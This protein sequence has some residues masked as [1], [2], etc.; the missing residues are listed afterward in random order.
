VSGIAGLHADRVRIAF[1]RPFAT[2]SGMWLEREAWLLLLTGADG[3]TGVGEAVLEPADGETAE[4]VLR[5]LI[6]EAVDGARAGR[7]PTAAELEGHGAPGRALRAALDTAWLDLTGEP[8]AVLGPGGAGVGVNAT[9]PALGPAASAEAARQAVEAG[10][11]TLK[12]KGGAERETE[13][14][15][16]RVRAVREAVG[17]AIRLR[18]DVN[19]AWDLETAVD[20]LGAVARFALEYVEQPL[21]GDDAAALASLRRRVRVPVAA[22]ETVSSLRTARELLD[23]GSVDVLVVKPARVGGPVAA[24]EIA[25]LAADRGV[26][27]VLSTLFETGIGI[28]SALAAAARLPGAGGSGGAAPDHGLATA[29]LLEHDLLAEAL[30]IDDGRMRLP[31]PD[32]TERPRPG[33]LG[34]RLDD[35]AVARFRV[36][37]MGSVP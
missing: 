21:G 11:R 26:P 13:V 6:R 20:R 16:D 17:P 35:R 2:S 7:L 9:L 34:V 14:L 31:E 29:G 5:L 12:L 22:D 36:E 10:F 27:V 19:G 18:L 15:V 1:R 23:A 32:A 8:P 3:R 25:A 33:G 37:S 4:S 30:P 24:A 28:A